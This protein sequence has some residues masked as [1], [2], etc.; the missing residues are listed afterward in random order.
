MTSTNSSCTGTRVYFA[1][2]AF[3]R[4]WGQ[5]LFLAEERAGTWRLFTWR[6]EQWQ[7][8]DPF[9]FNVIYAAAKPRI[10]VAQ[11][12]D[13]EAIVPGATLTDVTWHSKPQADDFTDWSV[14]VRGY[15]DDDSRRAA[16]ESMVEHG[17][18]TFSDADG[19]EDHE[20]DTSDKLSILEE[21]VPDS[22]ILDMH[23]MTS[24]RMKYLIAPIQ[25]Q[26]VV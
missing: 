24:I 2:A 21:T 26:R 17:D 19:H 14:L 3:D 6:D 8:V 1:T 7:Q 25:H 11:E 10:V 18:V 5:Y 4:A 9:D 22:E 20:L 16:L 23:D 12:S 15:L 13:V